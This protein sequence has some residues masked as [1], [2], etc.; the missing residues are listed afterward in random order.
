MIWRAVSF[1][2]S[3]GKL[4]LSPTPFKALH[5]MHISSLV[6]STAAPPAAP[7]C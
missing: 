5:A 2:R 6:C 1:M 3:L 4:P 7:L